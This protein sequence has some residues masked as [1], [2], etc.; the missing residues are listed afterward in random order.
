MV[1]SE[2]DVK[3]AV[4]YWT[5]RQT[6]LEKLRVEWDRLGFG[7][8]LPDRR[9]GIQL[10][11][12]ALLTKFPRNG[13][14]RLVRRM[15]SSNALAVVTEHRGEGTN[16]YDVLQTAKL[17][18]L[19]NI[20]TD[21]INPEIDLCYE[22][23]SK[24]LPG[25]MVGS[26]LIKAVRKLDGTTLRSSGGIYW[27]PPAGLNLLRHLAEGLEAAGGTQLYIL[28]TNFDT[29]TAEAVRD[30]LASEV[31]ATADWIIEQLSSGELKRKAIDGRRQKAQ[32]L[33]AKTKRYEEILGTVLSDVRNTIGEIE[34]AAA[35]A[36]LVLSATPND[37]E[38]TA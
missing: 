16:T 2:I 3:G 29:K 36:E 31:K 6:D 9:H 10:L 17:D 22:A 15:R 20:T 32:K 28:S 24:T 21:P 25:S 5:A 33:L 7:K 34:E 8:L 19:N 14:A 12:D 23:L 1:E 27:I 30:G 13:N 4:V 26:I 37:E 18:K 11:R 35:A 38:V